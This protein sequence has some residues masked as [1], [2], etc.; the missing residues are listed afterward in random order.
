MRYAPPRRVRAGPQSW[1]AD[2]VET[3]AMD[4]LDAAQVRAACEGVEAVYYLTHGMRGDD[5]ARTDREAA[6][7]MADGVRAQG[8]ERVVY[9]SGRRR[10]RDQGRRSRNRVWVQDRLKICPSAAKPRQQLG[11]AGC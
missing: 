4:A 7:N 10:R 11:G 5:F 8:V 1:W 2:R 9:L 6:T 3:V